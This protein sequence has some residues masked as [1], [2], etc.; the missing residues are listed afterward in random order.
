M[1]GLKIVGISLVTVVGISSAFCSASLTANLYKE[2]EIS[3]FSPNG[4]FL[5]NK[6]ILKETRSTFIDSKDFINL[7]IRNYFL[8]FES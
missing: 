2:K 7:V 6:K 1:K 4:E 5:E 8:Y 3:L